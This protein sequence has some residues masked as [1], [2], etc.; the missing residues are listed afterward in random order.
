MSGSNRPPIQ[1]VQRALL[2]GA[3]VG[4]LFGCGIGLLASYVYIQRNPPVYQSGAYPTELTQNYQDHYLA[5]VV[6][7]YTVNHRPELA[8]ERLKTFN[9]ATVI[10]ALG[11]WSAIYA[12]GGRATEAQAVNELAVALKNSEGWSDKAIQRA[13]EQLVAEYEKEGAGDKIQAVTTFASQLGQVPV[14]AET[15]PPAEEQ[16]PQETTPQPTAP[17]I[18]EDEGGGIPWFTVLFCLFLLVVILLIIYLLLKR[19]GLI[20]QQEPAKPEVVWEGEGVPPLKQWTGTY[21]LGEDNYDE[22]FTIETEDGDFLGESGMGILEALPGTDPKQVVAFDVGLFDKTDIKTISKVLMSPYA[23]NDEEI[24]TKVDN[25][26][27]AEAVLAEEGKQFNF[28][29][30]AMRIEV[31]VDEVEYGEGGET[32]FEKLTVSLDVFVKEGVDLQIG[33]MDVPEEY[34]Q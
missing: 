20:G 19:R 34:Q 1:G 29:S 23:Y 22:F 14:E 32:Y 25:N 16:P 5:M 2:V 11:R 33:H 4:I 30:S 12:A 6:D 8:Q 27:H 9:D 15:Q 31:S 24:R 26:P 13:V 3:L 18:E 7:S 21:T 28:E 17:P 10:K